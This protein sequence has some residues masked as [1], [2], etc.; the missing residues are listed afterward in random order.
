MLFALLGAMCVDQF[1]VDIPYENVVFPLFAVCAAGMS[2]GKNIALIALYAIIF[3]LYCVCWI[4][5]DLLSVKWWLLEVFI[6]YSMPY[7][8]YKA[9]NGKHKDMSVIA[10]SLIAAAGY[11]AYTQVSAVATAL[12]WKVP[13][14]AYLLSDLP[15]E[16]LGAAATFICA[17]P[18]AVLY[19]LFTGEL[20]LK[21]TG[22]ASQPQSH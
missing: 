8:I 20:V 17:L 9:V 21:K 18:V 1:V 11:L 4:P 3:E 13:Y 19:K 16:L 22:R 2:F 7:L 12:I 10:Y 14:G 6:G 5:A 15:Y